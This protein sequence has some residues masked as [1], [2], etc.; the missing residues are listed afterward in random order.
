MRNEA[1]TKLCKTCFEETDARARICPHCGVRQ[2]PNKWRH[3]LPRLAV[4]VLVL[5]ALLG[6][7][8]WMTSSFEKLA[9]PEDDDMAHGVHIDVTQS[10]MF[11][12]E[13]KDGP[14]VFVVGKIKNNSD[15]TLEYIEM[16]V[17]FRDAEGKLID[18]QVESHYLDRILPG[19]EM[20]F[21]FRGLAD[22][23]RERYASY[24]VFVRSAD[25]ARSSPW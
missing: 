21:K 6:F 2:W 18:V 23:P 1:E 17:E 22:L 9:S 5:V 4:G 7:P 16:E 24:E 14:T 8:G 10:E 15:T 19:G 11:Y 3:L 25:K 20:A 12:G 13:S